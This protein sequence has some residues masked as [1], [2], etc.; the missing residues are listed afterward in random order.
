M[1]TNTH[2]RLVYSEVEKILHK[3]LLSC[4]HW[5]QLQQQNL[6]HLMRTDYNSH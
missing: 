3:F 5:L 2:L 4:A 6:E 1:P